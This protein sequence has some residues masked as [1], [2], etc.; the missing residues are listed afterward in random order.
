[1]RWLEYAQRLS[2]RSRGVLRDEEGQVARTLLH[3][4]T[5]AGAEALGVDAGRITPGAWADLVAIDLAAPT[6]EGWEPD[7]LLESLIFGAAEEAIAGT[8]VGGAWEESG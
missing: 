1:M 4:A 2:T 6:L 5:T 8:C 3:A 7:T